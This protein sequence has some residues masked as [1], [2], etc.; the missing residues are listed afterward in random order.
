[1]NI[2]D[3]RKAFR[4]REE[5][6]VTHAVMIPLIEKENTLYILF[7]VRNR[8]IS[9]G[10]E[11]CFPGGRIETG[12]DPETALIREV[13]EELLVQEDQIRILDPLPGTFTSRGRQ[14]R[15]YTG[16]IHDYRETYDS[17]ETEKILLF[18]LEDLMNTKP[19]I[20]QVPMKLEFE[21]TFPFSQI[22]HGR[23]Y[24]FRTRTESFYFY[25]QDGY[26]I[27]GLTGRILYAFFRICGRNTERE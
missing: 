24:P 10:G 22:P 12:E 26:T 16:V 1:M 15:V 9:Q 4:N 14:V 8:N 3:I 20:Y 19:E 21:D 13:C 25:T 7:E 27:W 6:P 5:S 11:I 23:E 17:G 2:D 18:K